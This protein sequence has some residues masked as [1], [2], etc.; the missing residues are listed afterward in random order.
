MTVLR[1]QRRESL[2]LLVS[3]LVK[4]AS[5][6]KGLFSLWTGLDI[7]ILYLFSVNFCM[8]KV[9]N[10]RILSNSKG[11]SCPRASNYVARLSIYL[12]GV[13]K[14]EP[15]VLRMRKIPFTLKATAVF[16]I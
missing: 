11:T 10:K 4:S 14:N 12:E 8:Y 16:T 15:L 13:V 5:I 9:I 3:L 2:S 1:P 6:K 7:I